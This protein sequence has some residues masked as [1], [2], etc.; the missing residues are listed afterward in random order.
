MDRQTEVQYVI[1]GLLEIL[2]DDARLPSV[3]VLN[4]Y[5]NGWT[6]EATITVVL[7][8]YFSL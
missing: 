2:G 5:L 1:N 3:E 6:P 8:D 7:Q 4:R